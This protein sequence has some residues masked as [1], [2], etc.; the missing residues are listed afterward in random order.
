M[1][2]Y[3]AKVISVY[4]GDTVTLEVDLGFSFRFTNSYRLLRINCPELRGEFKEDAKKSRDRMR[5]LLL[6]KKVVIRTVKDA[7]EKYGRYLA[8]IE[9]LM[10][11]KLV[12][13][14]DLLVTEG[15]AKYVEY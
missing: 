13:I 3:N 15:L 8:E 6:N 1:Y 12:N 11:G 9:L 4:D 7:T 10:D 5:E 2:S 14:N